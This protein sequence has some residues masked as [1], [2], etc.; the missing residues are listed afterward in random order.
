MKTRF[1]SLLP[2][3][4]IVLLGSTAAHAAPPPACDMHLIVELTPDVPNPHDAGFLSSLL[5]DHPEFQLSWVKQV[6]MSFVALDLSGPGSLDRCEDVVDTMRRDGRV[7]SIHAE[8]DEVDSVSV[9]ADRD[10]SEENGP[11]VR[12]S[13]YGFGAVYW[14]AHHPSQAWRVV[15]PVDST[16]TEGSRQ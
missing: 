8:P 11:R 12:L 16:D 4:A 15:L 14:A 10:P 2:I 9:A 7:L 13:P 1:P 6:D 5:N 3:G